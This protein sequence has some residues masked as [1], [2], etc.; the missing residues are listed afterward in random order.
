MTRRWVR[1]GAGLFAAA[2]LLAAAVAPGY[3]GVARCA[4]AGAG[5]EDVTVREENVTF[6]EAKYSLCFLEGAVDALAPY[7]REYSMIT[8]DA[9]EGQNRIR[10]EVSDYSEENLERLSRLIGGLDIPAECVNVIDRTGV[11]AQVT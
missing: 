2:L 3:A 8:L 10:I 4:L 6:K 11:S 9:D 1:C 7:M 5:A